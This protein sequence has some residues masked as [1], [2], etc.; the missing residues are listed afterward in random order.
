MADGIRNLR[1]E[2]FD[3]FIRFL[4]RAFG[5]PRGNFERGYPHLYRPTPELCAVSFVMEQGGRIVSHVGV[6]PL[7]VQIQGVTWPIAGI[8]GVGTLPE[9]RGNGHMTRLLHHAVGVMR[10][11]GYPL[12][13]LIGDRQRYTSFGWERAGLSYEL[14]FSQ[15][16]L[17]RAGVEPVEVA[18]CGPEEALP[19][20][21]A[22]QASLTCRALRPNLTDQLR[23]EGLWIW[24]TE[25]GYALVLGRLFGP[26]SIAELV[27]T[28]GQEAA[29]IRAILDY[30]D[31]DQI[32][33]YVSGWDEE[34]LARLMPYTRNWRLGG[35]EM[36]RIVDLARALTLGQPFME[37]RAAVLRDL[38]LAIGMR[39]HRPSA[40][41]QTQAVTLSVRD[42]E[43]QVRPGRHADAYYEWSVVDA[44][45]LLL[46]GPPAARPQGMPDALWTGLRALA[47]IPAYLSPLDHV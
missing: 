32:T 38:E 18:V 7:E 41:D 6:Y 42:G 15:R 20:V 30:T 13:W 40:R 45:R 22:L 28:S 4:E 11:Q 16:S 44:T 26:L 37:R 29:L 21:Q 12:S 31:R 35:W 10:E 34:R 19:V 23:K 46:G 14:V 9:E 8:G 25:G 33:W 2:E 43:V 1:L 3:T 27:S 24:T 36:W 17:E 47:P 5:M 39:P